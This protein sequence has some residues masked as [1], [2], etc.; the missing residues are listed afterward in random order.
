M[1]Q[2]QIEYNDKKTLLECNYI[3][4][5]LK[6]T[7]LFICN[8]KLLTDFFSYPRDTSFKKDCISY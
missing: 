5:L 2:V 1:K 4:Y 8:I 3:V 7:N 6:I